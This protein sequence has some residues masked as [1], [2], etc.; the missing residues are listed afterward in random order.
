MLKL[1]CSPVLRLVDRPDRTS[2]FIL[3]GV[4][5]LSIPLIA[6]RFASKNKVEAFLAIP[7]CRLPT[8][9]LPTLQLANP[10]DSVFVV[11]LIT[12]LNNGIRKTRLNNTF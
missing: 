10:L 8:K 3:L 2:L 5:V 4:K 1:L 6:I 7:L 11:V 9:L 12:T